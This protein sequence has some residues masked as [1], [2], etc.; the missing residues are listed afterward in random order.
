MNEINEE[1]KVS[2]VSLMSQNRVRDFKEWWTGFLGHEEA[3]RL[4]GLEEKAIFHSTSG[5]EVFVLLDC[6]D[7]EK[8][9][10]FLAS[11]ELRDLKTTIGVTEAPKYHW[12][13]RVAPLTGKAGI[14]FHAFQ[15]IDA[16]D[17]KAFGAR[18]AETGCFQFANHSAVMGPSAVEGY[19]REFFS[20]L[21]SIRHEI[22]TTGF[23]S[24]LEAQVRG[25]VHYTRK[26]GSTFQ[27][28]FSNYVKIDRDGRFTN[29]QI[30]ADVNGLFA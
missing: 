19:C 16:M 2:P 23:E 20:N 24:Y 4:A 13:Q 5:E 15:E 9:K 1:K 14:L 25:T 21:K 11:R 10:A 7:E 6:A 17:A 30:F 29:W 27:A 3:R 18:F 8:A 12:G 22:Q 28:P 26:N